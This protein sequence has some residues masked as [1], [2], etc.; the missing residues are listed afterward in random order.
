VR[1]FWRDAEDAYALALVANGLAAAD[2]EGSATEA[3]LNRL[4]EMAVVEGN[5]AYWQS[6]IATFMGATGQTGSI[7]TTALAAYAFL[8][9]EQHTDLA[10]QAL[11][12]L[13]QQK[14]SYGTWH[15][16]QATILTLKALLLSVRKGGEGAD[17]TVTVSLNG[18]EADP[19]RIA[20]ENFDVV[21]M[22]SFSDKPIHG[23]NKVRIQVKGKGNLMYQIASRYYLPW[24]R[25][26]A[27]APGASLMD[28]GVSYDRTELAVN[29]VIEVAVHVELREGAARQAIVDLGIPPGFEVLSEDLTD[30]VARHSDLPPDYAGPKF[31]RFDLTGRQIIVYLEQLKAGEPLDFSYR[32]RAR[33][34][35]KAQTPPSSA[36]DYYN[37]GVSAVSS[38]SAITVTP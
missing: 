8:R 11:T 32:I 33:Y 27:P 37:P 26:P 30:L 6:D 24:D 13:I 22:V 31:S 5:G 36:Y 17:A 15:S 1:E 14:D 10:N 3:A 9:A 28:I 19:I 38:P 16:T 12:Y 23:D 18:E 4:A 25:V 7:E 35:I 20:E 21:Q 34:P 2:P 29:D